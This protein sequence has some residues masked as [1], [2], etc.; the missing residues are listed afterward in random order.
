MESNIQ[1]FENAEFGEIRTAAIDSQPWFVGK[2]IA[3]AL[4]YAKTSHAIDTHV[5]KGGHKGLAYKAISKTEK[6]TLWQGGGFSNKMLVDGSGLYGL[7]FDSRL[8]AARRRWSGAGFE[9][10]VM[11][12]RHRLRGRTAPVEQ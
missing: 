6:A 10:F 1:I 5:D 2:D 4:G 11:R 7:I 8:E 12:R 9:T 3:T